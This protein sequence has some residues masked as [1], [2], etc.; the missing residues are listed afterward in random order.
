M[1]VAFIIFFVVFTALSVL[2]F[3]G[4]LASFVTGGKT[5]DSGDPIYDEKAISKFMGIIML[6][7][8]GS[9]LVGLLGY[10]IPSAYVLIII[11]P[12]MF[13]AVLIFALV[14]VNTDGR[15]LTKG[16][17]HYSRKKRDK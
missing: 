4:K 1:L 16:A 6:L 12:V 14:Y 10:I 3:M 13:I 8:A 15:F 7:L 5:D 2:T 11:A 9:A 17:R